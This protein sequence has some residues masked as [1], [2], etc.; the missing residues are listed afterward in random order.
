MDRPDHSGFGELGKYGQ[1]VR[2]SPSKVQKSKKL[3]SSREPPASLSTA[4]P[5]YSLPFKPLR[6]STS[7]FIISFVL[8][9]TSYLCSEVLPT[10]ECGGI[11][12]LEPV[13]EQSLVLKVVLCYD[14]RMLGSC[15]LRQAFH[16][17][18][19]K[20]HGPLKLSYTLLKSSAL[21]LPVLVSYPIGYLGDVM[22]IPPGRKQNLRDRK[23]LLK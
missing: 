11:S 6:L 21:I 5:L 7:F 2:A 20:N 4:W 19:T 1:D 9:D 8:P 23:K 17:V 10:T 18:K 13:T 16:C 14:Q 22:S 12:P 15:L 3:Q